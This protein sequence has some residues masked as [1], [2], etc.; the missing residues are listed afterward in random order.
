M[1][2]ALVLAS[3][4]YPNLDIDHELQRVRLVAAEGAR[5]VYEENNPFAR[6][7]GLRQYFFEELGFHGDTDNYND[8]NNCYLHEVMNRRMGIPLT[9]SILFIEV[10]R[11]AGFEAVGIGLPGHFVAPTEDHHLGAGP[12][13][14]HRMVGAA[15]RHRIVVAVEAHQREAAGARR[16]FPARFEGH[17][18]HR[19]H[20]GAF[21]GQQVLFHGPFS[22]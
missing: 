2:A 21:L 12:F 11:A 14:H 17:R 15:H 20:D 1:E 22:A 3:E 18:W 19:Q 16:P 10:A 6:V 13:H 9:L 5:R 7:D 8:P 4:D